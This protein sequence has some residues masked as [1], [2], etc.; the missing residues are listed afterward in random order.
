METCV[1]K[2]IEEEA[3]VYQNGSLRAFN[4]VPSGKESKMVFDY[5]KLRK[6][7]VTEEEENSVDKTFLIVKGS[8]CIKV[9]GKCYCIS[10]GNAVWLPKNSSHIIENEMESME[11][12]VVKEK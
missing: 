11:F 4:L 6:G 10:E 1:T 7:S 3:G 8:G 12:I 5:V 9:D 2:F